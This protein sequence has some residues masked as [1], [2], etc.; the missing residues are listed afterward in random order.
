[1]PARTK[2]DEDDDKKT[3]KVSR[4]KKIRRDEQPEIMPTR[5][6]ST[7]DRRQAFYLK[8]GL[9]VKNL[10][11]MTSRNKA[12]ILKALNSLQKK[13]LLELI[14]NKANSTPPKKF[15]ASN[16]EI[17]KGGRPSG[18]IKTVEEKFWK[19]AKNKKCVDCG[20][21]LVQGNRGIDHK[22]AWQ[23]YVEMH[24]DT[25]HV[26]K[27]GAH[28]AVY[29]SSQVVAA[30]NDKDNLQAMCTSCNSSKSGPKGLDYFRSERLKDSPCYGE[31]CPLDEAE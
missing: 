5:L 8:L 25:F 19:Q 18:F 13:E 11:T 20:I 16:E 24:S 31:L 23:E 10:H 1:M 4:S 28:W 29:K 6:R 27:N 22:K 9:N 15:K 3:K 7:K 2:D 30:Y 17:W 21:P 12:K 26:C 14:K